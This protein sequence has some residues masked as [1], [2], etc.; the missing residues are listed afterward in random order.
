MFD[1]IMQQVLGMKWLSDAVWSL[2]VSF[3]AGKSSPIWGSLHFFL[4]DTIK[5]T[6]LLVSLIFL[7]SYIQSYKTYFNW[8]HRG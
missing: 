8:I 4:Y 7:I 5:I 1:F 3:G 2:L 6:I